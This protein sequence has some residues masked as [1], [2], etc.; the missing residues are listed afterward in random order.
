MAGRAERGMSAPPEV[1]FNTAIDP[2][3]YSGWLP[4]PLRGKDG[5]RPVTATKEGLRAR[6]EA[7]GRPGWSA[8]LRVEAAGAGGATVCLDLAAD[9]PDQHLAELADASLAGL[10]RQVADNLTAG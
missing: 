2:N 8:Q 7:D 1:V 6:W 9:E 5:A 3:R 10:A 4:E